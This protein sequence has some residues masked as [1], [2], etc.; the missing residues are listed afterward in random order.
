MTISNLLHETAISCS[1][2]V[3]LLTDGW[4][5]FDALVVLKINLP[6]IESDLLEFLEEVR[7]PIIIQNHLM[8]LT[9]AQFLIG[10]QCLRL[11]VWKDLLQCLTNLTLY[12]NWYVLFYKVLDHGEVISMRFSLC[13]QIEEFLV[14]PVLFCLK[15]FGA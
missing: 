14:Q 13:F 10:C 7:I 4:L 9:E 12:S 1:L 6:K 5:D 8:H 11:L 15:D 3:L 2:I